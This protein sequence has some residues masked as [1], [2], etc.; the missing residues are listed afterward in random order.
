MLS[1]TTDVIGI[2][3]LGPGSG[4]PIGGPNSGS[5]WYCH[6]PHSGVGGMTPLWN[7]QLSTASYTTYTSTTNVEKEN[8]LLPPGSDSALCLSCHDGTVAP[9]TTQ[10]YGK[11][12]VN[13]TW[14]QWR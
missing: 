5:C 10:A 9:G 2:H 3:N 4:S 8:S 6:A 14:T 12:P 7:Q 11:A 1:Q 13:G